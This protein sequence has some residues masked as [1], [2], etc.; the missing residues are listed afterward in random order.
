MN[1]HP[2]ATRT[3]A[4]EAGKSVYPLTVTA[5]AIVGFSL[6]TWVKV[7]T[8]GFILMQAAYLAWKW[9]RDWRRG[10]QHAHKVVTVTTPEDRQ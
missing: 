9:H 6:D 7:C 1:L 2:E 3:I 10:R 5:A 4:I 8:L